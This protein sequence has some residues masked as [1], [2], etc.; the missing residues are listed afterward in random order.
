MI[1]P[2]TPMTAAPRQTDW[3][4]IVQLSL[5]GLSLL[6]SLLAAGL[7]G[8]LGLA[9]VFGETGQ[10]QEATAVL[11]IAWVCLF[12]GA[13]TL[14][15]IAFSLRRLLR[16][17]SAAPLQAWK[18][19]LRTATLALIL[20]P[21]LILLGMVISQE[22]SL[23]WLVLPPIQ[24]LIIA[25]PT[26]WLVEV[27]R[28]GLPS[29]NQQ[30]DWGFVNISVFVTTPALMLVE[31][32]AIGILLVLFALWVSSQPALIAEIQRIAEQMI[33][34]PADP[35][36]ILDIFAPYL[37]NPWVILTVLGLAAGLVPFIEELIK[38]LAVWL[39]VGRNPSP[40]EG[41]A[42][43][44]L[45][46]A[47]FGLVESLLYMTN[48]TGDGW[49]ALAAGRTGTVLLHTA[50]TALVG[51][52]MATAWSSRRYARMLGTYLLAVLLHG[53]WNGLAILAG[54]GTALEDAPER[55]PVLNSLAT[56][57]P[58]AIA[59]LGLALFGVLLLVNSRLRQQAKTAQVLAT[60]SAEP[61]GD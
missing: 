29:S 53:L 2:S 25:I 3:I 10:T 43:G 4:S 31:I 13:L 32:L 38:P 15:S 22:T 54:F 12:F 57:A 46:G 7:F 50:T 16:G 23:G 37:S 51:W 61:R 14:P 8:V 20:W 30:R 28:R 41:F 59:V 18:G 24:L 36:A 47:T 48:P 27:A 17:D 6:L 26:W 45:C 52:G 34:A 19:G 42:A 55:L 5:S 21:L 39:L 9:M 49:A 11:G 33:S 58:V 40:A 44:A 35:E 60:A 56:A 1:P